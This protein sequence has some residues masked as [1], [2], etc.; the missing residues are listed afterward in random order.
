LE[1]AA[2][3][4]VFRGCDDAKHKTK[5]RRLYDI[6][7][8]LCSLHLIKKTSVAFGAGPKKPAFRWVGCNLDHVESKVIDNTG[9]P[10]ETQINIQALGRT[11]IRKQSL[12]PA[13]DDAES[14][15]PAKRSRLSL[16]SPES[17]TDVDDNNDPEWQETV[18]V[19]HGPTWADNGKSKINEGPIH[20]P[21]PKEFVTDS[22]EQA[23]QDDWNCP[24]AS[25]ATEYTTSP[26]QFSEVG[27]ERTP[28]LN[29]TICSTTSGG[30]STEPKQS[31][32]LSDS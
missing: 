29:H 16:S 27:S 6:A 17:L 23:V 24:N 2:D 20:R 30:S 3:R 10:E 11:R 7:N 14:S 1:D 18:T 28:Q 5:V 21:W 9:T 8:V 32:E 12:L 15:P 22:S 25:S 4:L 26:D 19:V 13:L 31:P